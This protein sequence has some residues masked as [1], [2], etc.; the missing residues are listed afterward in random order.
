VLLH[1]ALAG[2]AHPTLDDPERKVPNEAMEAAHLAGA[3]VHN[4]TD[5]LHK[6]F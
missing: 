2:V 1:R 6:V 5:A 4:L 3:L